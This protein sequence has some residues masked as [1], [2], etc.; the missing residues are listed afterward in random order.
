MCPENI[1]DEKN[2]I[3][4]SIHVTGIEFGYFVFEG[5]EHKLC[6]GRLR[7]TV[8]PVVR[9]QEENVV[10][11]KGRI[12]LNGFEEKNRRKRPIK[13]TISDSEQCA[14]TWYKRDFFFNTWPK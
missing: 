5:G 1:L 3:F 2:A 14:N 7:L 11:M 12:P 13:T 8:G 4:L 9:K 10:L 6:G